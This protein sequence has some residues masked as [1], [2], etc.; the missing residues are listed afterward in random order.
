M[1]IESIV[2]L[3]VSPVN[4]SCLWFSINNLEFVLNLG[5]GLNNTFLKKFDKSILKYDGIGILICQAI[6]SFNIWTSSNITIPSIYDDVHRVISDLQTD[7]RSLDKIDEIR[8]G[9]K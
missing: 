3:D 7:V 5:Y 1:P 6:E 4:I 9:S 2:I 8:K